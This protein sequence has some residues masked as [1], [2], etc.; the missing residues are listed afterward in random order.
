MRLKNIFNIIMYSFIMIVPMVPIKVKVLLF[1][2]SPDFIIGGLAILTGL[3]YIAVNYRKYKAMSILKERSII[4]T[5]ALIVLFV[6]MSLLSVLYAVNKG[7]VVSEA[8]RFLEYAFLFFLVLTI[9]DSNF[10]ER[11]LLLFYIVMILACV[12]GIVQFV[13][14]L[15]SFTVGGAFG[16][17]RVYSTFV[18]PNYWG[19]AVN[20]VIFFPIIYLIEGNKEYRVYNLVALGLFFI[21]L[22]LSFTR[23]AWLGFGLGLLL[24][25]IIRYRKVLLAFP[26]MLIAAFA[27]PFTRHRLLSAVDL[28]N[29]GTSERLTLWKTGWIMFKEHFWTGV[30]N[31]NYLYRYAEYIKRFPE[32]YLGRKQFSVHN[33]YIK[34]FAELGIFGGTIFILIYLMLVYLTYKVYRESR[35]YKLYALA[36]L[37]FWTAYLFQNFFNNLM[38]I[39]QLNVF[40]WIITAMLFK[41]LYLEGRR[42]S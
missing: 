27:I 11:G 33:S 4:I 41:G 8:L 39:P 38:F 26:A 6:A 5:T 9:A 13:F 40:V 20:L 12:F 3:G 10:I 34:M 29:V 31:G 25:C 42:F 15:S 24:L 7:A 2:M 36:F 22:I 19:A 30:G 18:N 23:G 1:P 14:N 37:A 28:N 16:R 21:N 32:L 35:K 17:G